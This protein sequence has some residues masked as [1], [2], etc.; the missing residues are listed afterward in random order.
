MII[1]G[2]DGNRSVVVLGILKTAKGLTNSLIG[3]TVWLINCI[4]Q[5]K[6]C[7]YGSCFGNAI[8][9]ERYVAILF[10]LLATHVLVCIEL[11]LHI[12]HHASQSLGLWKVDVLG[13]SAL[14]LWY[15]VA[16]TS[17]L[18]GKHSIGYAAPYTH[19]FGEVHI[20]CKAVVLLILAVGG[21]LQHLLYVAKVPNEVIKVIDAV[22]THG[23]GWH[24]IA[25]ECPYLGSGVADGCAGGKHY[26]LAVLVLQYGLRL[27]IHALRLLAVRGV[28]TFHSSLHGGGKTKVLVFVCLINEQGINAHIVK[29]GYI[30]G[31][32]V[33]HLL[34]LNS[35]ILFTFSFTLLIFFRFSTFLALLQC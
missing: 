30:I 29:V 27:E 8:H 6:T 1:V 21:K 15:L 10:L 3:L 9:H 11:V 16:H 13:L 25:H 7:I 14:H 31:L 18:T 2:K 5:Y 26:V 35:R 12:L 17:S 34:C 22:L 19:K 23:V 4:F 32:T 20:T 28:Y 24:Q 33:E